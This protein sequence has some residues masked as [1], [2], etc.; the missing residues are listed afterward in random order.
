MRAKWKLT[1]EG[2]R[3]QELHI[4]INDKYMQVGWV[5]PD[6]RKPDTYYAYGVWI[7]DSTE[8]P[9]NKV[10]ETAKQARRA[11]K[12]AAIVAV[13]GGFDGINL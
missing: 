8:Y 13:V 10:F 1:G 12:A 9:E 11:L 2:R 3:T 5:T 7:K 4:K 6:T